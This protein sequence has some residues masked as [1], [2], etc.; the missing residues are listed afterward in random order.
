MGPARE[1]ARGI[2]A[3]GRSKTYKRRCVWAV[4]KK[5]GGKFPTFPKKEKEAPAATKVRDAIK[6]M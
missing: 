3:E 5:N 1:L 4:K 6:I 2:S